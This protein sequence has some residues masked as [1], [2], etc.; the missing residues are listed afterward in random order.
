MWAVVDDLRNPVLLGVGQTKRDAVQEPAEYEGL[1]V[2]EW[3]DAD[4]NESRLLP[5]TARVSERV[6]ADS[7]PVAVR[8]VLGVAVDVADGVTDDKF[9]ELWA[10]FAQEEYAGAEDTTLLIDRI[11]K[12]GREP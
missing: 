3:L 11:R 2:Q 1:T 12:Q 9:D 6:A 5:C 7:G 8:V 10:G 4:G